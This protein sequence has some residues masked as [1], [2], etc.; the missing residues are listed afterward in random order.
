M[1][2]IRNK[3]PKIHRLK[4]VSTV[5]GPFTKIS[6][7][8]CRMIY[9]ARPLCNTSSE[10]GALLSEVYAYS[11]ED[12]S[13]LKF[14]SQNLFKVFPE[15][16]IVHDLC[17]PDNYRPKTFFNFRS[18]HLPFD[19]QFWTR[20][21]PLVMRS[22]KAGLSL[23]VKALPSEVPIEN[24]SHRK[25]SKSNILKVFWKPLFWKLRGI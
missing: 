7:I 16:T 13:D 19:I 11:I 18:P 14:S 1:G 20:G 17:Y 5:G 9:Y 25:F 8:D 22:R 4:L 3:R 6:K 23:A 12:D 15:T 10:A 2:V 21:F 24:D